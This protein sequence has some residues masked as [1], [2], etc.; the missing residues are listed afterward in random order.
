MCEGLGFIPS[1]AENTSPKGEKETASW[2]ADLDAMERCPSFIFTTDK[3]NFGEK[4]FKGLTFQV[5]IYH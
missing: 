2:M 5:T 4:G 3:S 1:I